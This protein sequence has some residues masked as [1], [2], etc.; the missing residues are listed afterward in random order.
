MDAASKAKF[1]E[2][3]QSVDEVLTEPAF[4]ETLKDFTAK[5]CETFESTEENKL[6]YTP[7][8]E[9]YAKLVDE[10][11]DQRLVEKGIDLQWFMNV[12]PDHMEADDAHPRTGAV[13]ELL[14]SFDDFHAFKDMMIQQKKALALEAAGNGGDDDHTKSLGDDM[15][16][17]ALIKEKLELTRIL[18]EGGEAEGWT[19]I[20]DKG[21]IQ[22]FKKRDPNSPINL[23]R[24]FATANVPPDELMRIFMDPFTKTKWDDDVTTCEVLGGEGFEKDGFIVRQVAKMPLMNQREMIWRWIWVK[25][26]PEP[27]SHTG[28]VHSEPWD[29]P[30]PP[31]T[32][33][34]VAKIGNVIVRPLKD[35][36]SKSRMTMFAHMDF[37]L[38][39]FIANHTSSNWMVRNVLKLEA[40]YKTLQLQGGK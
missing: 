16:A 12:L 11:V 14:S 1:N 8:F 10:Y 24:C 34:A 28:I 22:T 31:N 17:L 19:L 21:W 7:I 39:A 2:A 29:E 4:V 40:A 9:S 13:L 36:P 26:H 23:T 18:E 20:A 37:G 30:P 38:P 3:V 33:R 5:H 35:D 27:G 25:D 32:F 6:E 15:G